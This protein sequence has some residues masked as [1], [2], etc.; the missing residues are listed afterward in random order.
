MNIDILKSK[1]AAV[2]ILIIEKG[3]EY[4]LLTKRSA[5]LKSHPGQI[6]FPG[7]KHDSVDATVVETAIREAKEE[8]GLIECDVIQVLQPCISAHGLL[9]YPVLAKC[10]IFE[11][12]ANPDEVDKIYYFEFQ[13]MLEPTNYQYNDWD[14]KNSKFYKTNPNAIK[15]NKSTIIRCHQ[16]ELNEEDC[17]WGL[18]SELALEAAIFYYK[19]QPNFARK[20]PSQDFFWYEITKAFF[21]NCDAV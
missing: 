5:K 9:V 16:F 19:K 7:G 13:L 8:I 2:L 21:S 15:H 14:V 12:I 11:P 3:K 1:L 10:E 20:S 4:I 17:L 18:T 6:C